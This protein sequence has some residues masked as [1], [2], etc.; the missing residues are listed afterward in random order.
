M[1]NIFVETLY[2]LSIMVGGISLD[3]FLSNTFESWSSISLLVYSLAIILV[4]ILYH[5]QATKNEQKEI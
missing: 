1:V 5:R 4:G 3:R 2:T